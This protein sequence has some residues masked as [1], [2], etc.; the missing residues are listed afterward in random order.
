VAVDQVLVGTGLKA[1]PK[2]EAGSDGKVD[3]GKLLE[4]GAAVVE[5]QAQP[6]TA[7]A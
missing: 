7:S 3:N 1:E 6:A 5:H 4:K 2:D